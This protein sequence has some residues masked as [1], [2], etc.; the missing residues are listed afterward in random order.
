MSLTTLSPSVYRAVLRREVTTT[1]HN[2]FVQVFALVAWTGSGAVVLLSG[3]AEAVPY[4]LL[5]LF[6]Y[7]VPLFGLLVGVSA[8][9]EETEE[10]A[11]LWSQPVPR[12]LFVLSKAVTLVGALTAVLLGALLAGVVAGAGAGALGLLGALGT[13]LVL[14]SVS[15]GLTVGQYTTSPA[16]GLM[17]GLVVWVGAFALYDAVA[18]ALSGLDVTQQLPALWVGLLLLNPIDAVRLAGLFALEGVPFSTPGEATWMADLVAWL[19]AWVAGLT[20]GWTAALLAL[21]CRRLRR[22]DL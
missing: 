6:L 5:L 13:G 4:G 19:P 7:L 17:V 8:A 18:L 22:L 12:S 16:R 3:R 9:H 15:A 20:A 1:L 2:R 21:A 10:R 11:F 14:V